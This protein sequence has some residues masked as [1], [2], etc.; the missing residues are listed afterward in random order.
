MIGG[1]P[2][3]GCSSSGSLSWS[4]MHSPSRL[5]K[6]QGVSGP[7]SSQSKL[8]GEASKGGLGGA[9]AAALT[10]EPFQITRRR[11]FALR[12]Q[13]TVPPPRTE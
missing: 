10:A 6:R 11:P 9:T 7:V 5:T 3:W 4:N 2:M 13:K 8:P 12:R 1:N